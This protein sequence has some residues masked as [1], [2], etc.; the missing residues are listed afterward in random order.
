MHEFRR[1]N[2]RTRSSPLSNGGKRTSGFLIIGLIAVVALFNPVHLGSAPR[3]EPSLVI[4]SGTTYTAIR[5]TTQLN[6][7]Q[8]NVNA[9]RNFQESSWELN[10]NAARASINS[11]DTTGE[12]V[13][14]A[15]HLDQS[16]ISVAQT[17]KYDFQLATSASI[18]SSSQPNITASIGLTSSNYNGWYAQS[19]TPVYSNNTKTI[20]VANI[21]GSYANGSSRRSL[22]LEA[23]QVTNPQA[24]TSGGNS[25]TLFQREY[26]GYAAGDGVLHH[27]SIEIDLQSD[28]TTWVVDDTIIA[29]FKLSFVPS[30]LVFIA[31]AA[32]PGNSAVARLEDPVQTALLPILTIASTPVTVLTSSGFQFQIGNVTSSLGHISSLQNQIDHLNNQV[33]NLTSQNGQ[34][35]AKNSQWFSQWWFSALTGLLGAIIVGSF[36][37]T[38]VRLRNGRRD[39]ATESGLASP[40]SNC[41]GQMPPEA[42]FCGE[43][44]MT[45]RETKPVCPGC[46]G[47]MPA[48]SIYCGDC[49]TQIPVGD[50]SSENTSHASTSGSPDEDQ[51]TWR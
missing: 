46:G 42:T 19:R 5:T 47:Q 21:V 37:V 3:Q 8:V 39:I 6:L 16:G 45:L 1:D 7:T 49:G 13:S 11:T 25:T 51:D 48:A 50:P 24:N 10:S 23:Q 36:F 17:I 2:R 43:C 14:A 20:S 34:L 27:Y 38:G 35:Q 32:T 22:L 12:T 28:K 26:P 30:N 4:Q 40:C 31:S 9:S 44:G 33:G 41:G 15:L 18:P 29:V